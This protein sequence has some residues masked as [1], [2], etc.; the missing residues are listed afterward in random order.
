M[1]KKVSNLA[2]ISFVIS[3]ALSQPIFLIYGSQGKSPILQLTTT[4]FWSI[5]IILL[6]ILAHQK[7][8]LRRIDFQSLKY[9]KVFFRFQ[10]TAIFIGLFVAIPKIGLWNNTTAEGF[11]VLLAFAA[12]MQILKLQILSDRLILNLITFFL[13]LQ[14]TFG[15]IQYFSINTLPFYGFNFALVSPNYLWWDSEAIWGSF[16]NYGKNSFGAFLVLSSCIYIPQLF[17]KARELNVKKA[18][19]ILI[20][21]QSLIV[22]FTVWAIY[23][24]RSRTS[25]FLVSMILISE[26]IVFLHRRRAFLAPFVYLTFASLALF[27]YI[28]ISQN[29]QLN[30]WII[31]TESLNTRLKVA[32]ILLNSNEGNILVG[33]GTGSVFSHT[34]GTAADGFKS[35]NFGLGVNSDNAFIRTFVEN[36]LIGLIFMTVGVIFFFKFLNKTV[37]V[38]T[39]DFHKY[40]A[41]IYLGITFI[42]LCATSDFTSIHL[43]VGY[44]SFLLYYLVHPKE[45]IRITY[46]VDENF[47]NTP[48]ANKRKR[49]GSK[50]EAL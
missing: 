14:I 2:V 23:L 40:R 7:T 8:T 47:K 43:L 10:I 1:N 4:A 50:N 45:N 37:S 17:S 6:P 33:S 9:L 35:G 34:D 21:L 15:A 42:V 46:P 32:S 20:I 30:S 31:S 16:P 28:K 18:S 3:I 19:R 39:V 38:N 5:V 11:K 44:F 41:G 12:G 49:R 24:A 22:V 26:V 27:L 36:G 29:F 48:I 13:V 25:L